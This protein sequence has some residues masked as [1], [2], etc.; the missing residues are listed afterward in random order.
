[1]REGDEMMQSQ[2]SQSTMTLTEKMEL[3][4]ALSLFPALTIMVFLRRKVGYRFLSPLRLQAMALLLWVLSAF[5]V[6]SGNTL[7]VSPLI[8]FSL[9]MLIAGYVER[10]LRWQDIKSGLSWHSYSRG[11]SWF[12]HYVPLNE[13]AVKRFVDPAA[14]AIIGLALSFL[15]PWLGYYIMFSA[16]CLFIFEA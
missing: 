9:A 12:S 1:M 8:V 6:F 15:F 10:W 14:A 3:V 5:S 13:T 16:V 7:S 2:Q 4:A 11:I